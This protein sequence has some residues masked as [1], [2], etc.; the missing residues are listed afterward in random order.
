MAPKKRKA[1]VMDEPTAPAA[2]KGTTTKRSI[3]ETASSSRPSRTSLATTQTPR[4][5]RSSISGSSS[6][7]STKLTT[8]SLGKTNSN[9][10][11]T[12][13]QKKGKKVSSAS[14]ASTPA[15][16]ERHA[17]FSVDVP[18][19]TTNGNAID[20]EDEYEHADGPS[21]W[22]MKAE[23]NSRIEK[24][25]DVKFSIDDLKAATAPEAWDGT[26]GSL[27]FRGSFT[28]KSSV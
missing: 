25:N 6:K 3:E 7:M 9:A 5:T 10:K 16:N 21:Y 20:H 19:K 2:K 1:D 26:S 17:T 23:P 22:L 14:S 24:G 8:T 12:R 11:S 4:S 15:E 28:D 13:R 27:S 18:A